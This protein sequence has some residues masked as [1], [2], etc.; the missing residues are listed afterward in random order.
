MNGV[1]ESHI[2]LGR[3]LRG[4]GIVAL[5]VLLVWYIHFQARNFIQ[6]PLVMLEDYY[7]PI[8][9]E[10]TLVLEGVAKNIVRLTLNGREITT[11]AEGHF[12]ET[13]HLERGYSILSLH[14]ED[15]F[16]R[17]TTVERA[18]VYLPKES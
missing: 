6:G 10:Q 5:V 16:G 17:A 13:V 9:H 3:I 15:R 7:E 1:K 4:I 2:T 12:G 18:Y 11:N 14:A 8:Q